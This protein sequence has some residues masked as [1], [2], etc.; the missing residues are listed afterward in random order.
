MTKCV[1]H[2][3][4]WTQKSEDDKKSLTAQGSLELDRCQAAKSRV[5]ALGIVNLL[6][7]LANLLGIIEIIV[8]SVVVMLFLEGATTT[9]FS[10]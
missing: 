5:N 3:E 10:E 4:N 1:L 7:P 2:P 6:N 8:L 9:P